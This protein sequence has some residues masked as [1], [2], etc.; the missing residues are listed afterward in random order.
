MR[1]VRVRNVAIEASGRAA[2]VPYFQNV[3]AYSSGVKIHSNDQ[4]SAVGNVQRG[5]NEHSKIC[6]QGSLETAQSPL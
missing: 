3:F 2:V 4:L 6:R 5:T 1:F